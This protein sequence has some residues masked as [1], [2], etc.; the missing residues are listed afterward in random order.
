MLNDIAVFEESIY[1]SIGVAAFTALKYHDDKRLEDSSA[2]I[3]EW[4]NEKGEC[5]LTYWFDEKMHEVEGELIW[6]NSEEGEKF[7]HGTCHF[8]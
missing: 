1:T 7:E 8:E 3:N 4:T 5:L 2:L 6:C